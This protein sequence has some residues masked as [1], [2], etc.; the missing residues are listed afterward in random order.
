MNV[1]VSLWVLLTALGP[2][3]EVDESYSQ[4]LARVLMAITLDSP[5]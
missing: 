4:G 3:K 1:G 5:G 2:G